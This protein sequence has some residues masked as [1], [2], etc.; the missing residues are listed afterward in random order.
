MSPPNPR[1]ATEHDLDSL[2]RFIAARNADPR[3]RCLMLPVAEEDIRGDMAE[4][5]EE[6]HTHFV[7]AEASGELVGA[8]ACDW[9]S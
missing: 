3:S 6:A 2:A 7:V 8:A 9:G 5:N 4:F 1:R